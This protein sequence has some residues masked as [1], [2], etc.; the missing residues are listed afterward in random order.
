MIKYLRL[1]SFVA[2][3][4]T[5]VMSC[6]EDFIDLEPNNQVSESIV[7]GSKKGITGAL[8]G[9]M[10]ELI[11][12]GGWYRYELTLQGDVLGGNYKFA[13]NAATNRWQSELVF[14]FTPSWTNSELWS[15]AYSAC[16]MANKVITKIDAIGDMTLDEKNHVKGQAYFARALAHFDLC[17][18]FAQPYTLNDNSIATGANGDGGHLGVIISNENLNEDKPKRSTLKECYQQIISDLIEAEKLMSKNKF[19]V[20]MPSQ[21]AA[22]ALLSRVYLY[23]GDFSNSLIYSDKV[24]GNSNNRVLLDAVAYKASW[25]EE[26]SSE[27]IFTAHQYK[28]HPDFPSNGETL[29]D[30]LAET[31]TYGDLSVSN[32]LYSIIEDGDARKDLYYLD[33]R[34]VSVI[35]TAKYTSEESNIPVIRISEIYLNK[36][37]AEYNS[38]QSAALTTLNNFRAKRGLN[39]LSLSDLDL[40]NAI[41]KER[42]IELCGEGHEICDL[43]RTNRDLVRVDFMDNERKNI[44]YPSKLFALPIPESELNGNPNCEQNLY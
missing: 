30:L 28:S 2:V 40:L 15:N 17:K 33:S 20:F 12:N 14:N 34:D 25:S 23:K 24:I 9:I 22:Q 39:A 10:G 42:R 38:D 19:D 29:F 21:L 26:Y 5:V 8:N 35:R 4:A 37:E 13:T 44:S 31:G 27:S 36:A 16:S 6:S 7:F 43:V 11:D 1:F 18:V 3:L 32:D 41:Y